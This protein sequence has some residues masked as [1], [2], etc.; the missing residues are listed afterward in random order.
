MKSSMSVLELKKQA[1]LIRRDII[2]MCHSCGRNAHPGPALS[3]ADICTAVYYNFMD[4]D[5]TEP[6]RENRDCFILSK[7]HAAPVLYAL[8]ANLGFFPKDYYKTLRHVD[9][10]LQ[11]HPSYGKTPGVDMTSGS[12]GNGLGIGLGMAYYLKLK[13]FQKKVFVVIGDGELNEGT[14]W[15][16]AAVAPA[17]KVDNLIAIVDVNGFQSCGATK[18][19][20]PMPNIAKR[21]Q[22][23]GWNVIK[24]N[25]NDM[26][27]IVD[28][29]ET[30]VNNTGT[31]T[32]IVA[33]CIKGKGVSFMENNN[34]WHQKPVS[35]E[36][37]EIAM[38]ELE[39]EYES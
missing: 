3:C 29:L 9:G 26:S 39:A 32:C 34:A 33:D 22:Y 19:I 18:D 15:E 25:G 13:G 17:Q 27:E 8:L 14:V 24:I 35:D 1:N 36:E 7:G 38:K 31:P 5:P 2:E 21:W 37:Y 12:L 6:E 20:C 30:A 10:K 23:F 4:I 28:A 16:A 11:G